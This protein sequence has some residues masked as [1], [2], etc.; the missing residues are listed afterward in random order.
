MISEREARF[1]RGSLKACVC[2]VESVNELQ[3]QKK[4]AGA[5][6]REQQQVEPSKG[7]QKGEETSKTEQVEAK[8]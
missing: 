1:V 5:K 6:R 4:R 7:K 8:R 3:K 2:K